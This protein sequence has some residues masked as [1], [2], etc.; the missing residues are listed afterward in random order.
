MLLLLLIKNQNIM[1]C[2]KT[3]QNNLTIKQIQKSPTILIQQGFINILY[4][5][6]LFKKVSKTYLHLPSA[7]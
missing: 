2:N 4:K 1:K 6:E 5:L 7:E 3:R